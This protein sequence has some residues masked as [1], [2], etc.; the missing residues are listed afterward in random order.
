M[1]KE[2]E[3]NGKTRT[4]PDIHI[5]YWAGCRPPSSPLK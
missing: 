1:T 3:Y 2:F 5:V 4:Y